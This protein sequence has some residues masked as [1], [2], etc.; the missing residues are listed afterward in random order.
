MFR[1]EEDASVSGTMAVPKIS[2]VKKTGF[3]IHDSLRIS[4]N[5]LRFAVSAKKGSVKILSFMAAKNSRPKFDIKI[6]GRRETGNVI[7]IN[8]ERAPFKR[9]SP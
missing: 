3:D 2:E 4:P 6:N 8:Q 7:A 9:P 5:G 1:A